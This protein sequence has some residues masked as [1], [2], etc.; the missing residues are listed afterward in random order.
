[1]C[2]YDN[3]EVEFGEHRSTGQ[4]TVSSGCVAVVCFEDGKNFIFFFML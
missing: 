2:L 3:G 4:V 1:M